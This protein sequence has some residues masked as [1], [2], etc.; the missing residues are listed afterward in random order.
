MAEHAN[1]LY[2]NMLFDK[3]K[4]RDALKT[5]KSIDKKSLSNEE[6]D[7]C[8]FK[9][10]YCHYQTHDIAKAT[11]IFKEL[12]NKEN[13]YRSDARYYYAHILYINKQTDESLKYFNT[14]KN[15]KKYKN[16]NLWRKTIY[17]NQER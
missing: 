1:F 8:K 11:P 14:L 7:E 15:N 2:G 13:A 3:R 12:A 5:Y 9:E 10:A 16:M 6:Q 17:E 4:Y